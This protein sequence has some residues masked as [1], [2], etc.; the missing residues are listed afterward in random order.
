MLLFWWLILP[1]Q[2]EHWV[3]DSRT[4]F[5]RPRPAALNEIIWRWEPLIY[6]DEGK[7][8]A[9]CYNSSYI[10]K[11]EVS[12]GHEPHAFVK[13]LGGVIRVGKVCALMVTTWGLAPTNQSTSKNRVT[14]CSSIDRCFSVCLRMKKNGEATWHEGSRI[15]MQ[16]IVVNL[17]AS[18]ISKDMFVQFMGALDGI[19]CLL[20]KARDKPDLVWSTLC[21]NIKNVLGCSWTEYLW[22]FKMHCWLCSLLSNSTTLITL[23]PVYTNNL[24]PLLHIPVQDSALH[25][26]LALASRLPVLFGHDSLPLGLYELLHVLLETESHIIRSTA[27][28][29]IPVYVLANTCG[30]RNVTIIPDYSWPALSAKAD[31]LQ[32]YLPAIQLVQR[33]PHRLLLYP[34]R[35]SFLAIVSNFTGTEPDVNRVNYLGRKDVPTKSFVS[36]GRAALNDFFRFQHSAPSYT[37]ITLRELDIYFCLS[38]ERLLD[39]LRPLRG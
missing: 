32:L 9:K 17:D 25:F 15:A 26:S 30:H 35:C 21:N 31:N 38:R 5:S 28:S 36:I 11:P 3:I 12:G 33:P 29:K 2:N 13:Y 16:R 34:P 24:P 1:S 18:G 23:L 6:E 27:E 7:M 14:R 37:S 22:G 10:S 39:P 19:G 20:D 8:L 4:Q